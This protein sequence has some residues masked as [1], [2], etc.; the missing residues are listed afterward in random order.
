[1]GDEMDSSQTRVWIAQCLCPQRHC[2]MAVADEATDVASAEPIR[3]KLIKSVA[4][5]LR[6]KAINPW[7][8]LCQSPFD[9]W[10]YELGRTQ[11]GSTAEALPALK[12]LAAEQAVTRAIFGDMKRSD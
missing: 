11:W 3:V 1:M 7:C 8:G 6:T 12:Q 10:R 2:V 4:D 9:S 5:L